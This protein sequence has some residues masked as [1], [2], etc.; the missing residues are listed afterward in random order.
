MVQFHIPTKYSKIAA[1]ISWKAVPQR[2]ESAAAKAANES[3][4]QEGSA[5]SW[6]LITT[7]KAELYHGI[8]SQDDVGTCSDLSIEEFPQLPK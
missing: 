4:S 8:F 3:L 1:H 5:V 7:D 2:H 6:W